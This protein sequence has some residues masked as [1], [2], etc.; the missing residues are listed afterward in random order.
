M[1]NNNNKAI[2]RLRDEESNPG[3]E[4]I[5]RSLPNEN[6]MTAANNHNHPEEEPDKDEKPSASGHTNRWPWRPAFSRSR[7]LTALLA[8]AGV[9]AAVGGGSVVFRAA[10][11]GGKPST[12]I[13]SNMQV[14]NVVSAPTGYEQVGNL[15]DGYCADGSSQGYPGVAYGD[16]ATAA[17]CATKCNTCVAVDFTMFVGMNHNPTVSGGACLCWV[18]QT[19][20]LDFSQFGSGECAAYQ[21]NTVNPG[22]GP[23]ARTNANPGWTCYKFVGGGSETDVPSIAPSESSSDVPSASA[24]PSTP[25]PSDIPSLA[26]STS[27]PSASDIPSVSPTT[28]APSDIPSVPPSSSSSPTAKASKRPKGPKAST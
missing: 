16:I 5:L 4:I 13:T 12:T 17:A 9:G 14:A 20:S 24:P 21:A 19:G 6:E 3:H 26:P 18:S 28:P 8:A 10:G 1:S 22:T 7:A 25:A 23:I 11:A 15:G 2:L 27:A